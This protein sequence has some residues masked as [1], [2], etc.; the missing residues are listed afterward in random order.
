MA[1]TLKA[2]WTYWSSSHSVPAAM[3][4]ERARTLAFCTRLRTPHSQRSQKSS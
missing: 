4:R 1:T 2:P 3:P